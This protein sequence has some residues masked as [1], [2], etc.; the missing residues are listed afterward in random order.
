M[1]WATEVM[2]R[3]TEHLQRLVDDLLD[4]AR[5]TSGKVR[6]QR[7]HVDIRNIIRDA[8]EATAVLTEA[9]PDRMSMKLPDAPL[10]VFGDAA[11]LRQVI[12]NLLTN[13]SKYSDKDSQIIVDA[14]HEHDDVVIRVVDKGVGIAPELLPRVF[15]LFIQGDQ[16]IDRA[17][18]GLG[19]GLTLVRQLVEMHNGR[20]EAR[21][22]GVGKGSEFIVRLPAV[23]ERPQPPPVE[24]EPA[25]A[26]TAA[27]RRVLIVDDNVDFADGMEML[28][29]H[30]GHEARVAHDGAS[31]IE[32][33]RVFAPDVVLL[34]LGLPGM[35]GFETAQALRAIPEMRDVLLIAISGYAQEEDRRRSEREGF[36]GHLTKPVDPRQVLALLQ[37]K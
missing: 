25:N 22:E 23:Q 14:F 37:G 19:I 21:S 5:I 16:S 15:E 35:N 2:D 30:E 13:A 34:D 10:W 20:V 32:I 24:P 33:A 3:Q 9:H 8:V 36:S 28:L 4:V 27:K 7:E 11:R 6:L 12:G 17:Q 18:G 29:D 1:K 31:A 26:G